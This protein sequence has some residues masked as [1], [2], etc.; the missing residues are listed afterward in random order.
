M[1]KNKVLYLIAFIAFTFSSLAGS[2]FYLPFQSEDRR[3]FKQEYITPAGQFGI[4][5]KPYNSIQGHFHAGIDF[6]N[7]GKKKGDIQPVFA[8]YYGKVV[9]IHRN[10]SS[11]FIIIS[12]NIDNGKTIHSVYVHVDDIV[13]EPG[14]SVTPYTVIASFIDANKLDKWGEYLNHLHFEVLR[15]D[16]KDGGYYKGKRF[17]SSYSIDCRTRDKLNRLYYNPELFFIH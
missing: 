12:H 3:T 9:S 17:Y 8:C 6:V 14:D 4:W 10:G 11:S 7:P 2:L 15:A 16:P 1:R 5:R 13:V